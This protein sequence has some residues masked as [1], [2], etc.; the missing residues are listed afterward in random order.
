[1]VQGVCERA[2]VLSAL[3]DELKARQRLWNSLAKGFINVFIKVGSSCVLFWEHQE[4]TPC[5]S[6][7]SPSFTAEVINVDNLKSENAS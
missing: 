5:T 1:L 7:L 2:L 6:H 4:Y 3:L